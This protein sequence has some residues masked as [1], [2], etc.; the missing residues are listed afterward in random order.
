MRK[1]LALV[2][3]CA[4]GRIAWADGDTPWDGTYIND[5][6][7]DGP[8]Y[9]CPH[10]LSVDVRNGAYSFAW[11]INTGN[12][13]PI[14]VGTI[15]GSVRASGLASTKATLLDPLPADA[16]A[17]LRQLD[18]RVDKLRSA[19]ASM[20]VAFDKNVRQ[21]SLHLSDVNCSADWV[22]DGPAPAAPAVKGD[23]VTAKVGGKLGPTKKLKPPPP[24]PAGAPKWDTV[25]VPTSS[26]SEDWRCPRQEFKALVVSKGRFTIPYTVDARSG[27]GATYGATTLGQIDGSIAVTGKVALR[28][29][30]SVSELPP[31]ITDGREPSESTL[32]YVRAFGLEMTFSTNGNERHAR[33][34][35]GD[36]CE[37]LLESKSTF[38]PARP[39]RSRLEATTSTKPATPEKR[40]PKQGARS[41]DSDYGRQGANVDRASAANDDSRKPAKT[42]LPDSGRHIGEECSRND[43]CVSNWCTGDHCTH[44]T[45]SRLPK[46]EHCDAD[47]QCLSDHC[48]DSTCQAPR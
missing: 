41:D 48:Y 2:V 3:A 10:P 24:L 40:K 15:S 43:Q 7:D 25:Y 22:N 26:S 20:T 1:L 18:E 16:L 46:G 42:Q 29:W 37:I 8:T 45:N 6:D 28:T 9:L 36:D 13:K 11:T 21:R 12:D 17:A 4:L 23:T 39:K 47:N 19:A 33:L 27:R 44:K 35:A 31:E 5:D 14:R 34:S 32:D 38:K 30:F